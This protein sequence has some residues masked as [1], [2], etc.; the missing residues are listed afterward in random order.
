MPTKR[1]RGTEISTARS[2]IEAIAVET[3]IRVTLRCLSVAND[4][5]VRC[6]DGRI[7]GEELSLV[8]SRK[9]MV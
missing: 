3:I 9:G 5:N 2:Q 7:R 1:V 4:F 6:N 8:F